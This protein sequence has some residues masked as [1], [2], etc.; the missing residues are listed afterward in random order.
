MQPPIETS[1]LI[2]EAV[3]DTEL[4]GFPIVIHSELVI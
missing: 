2:D 3:T 1:I 4:C